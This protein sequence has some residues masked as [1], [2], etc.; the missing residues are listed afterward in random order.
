MR[1]CVEQCDGDYDCCEGN[2]YCYVIVCKYDVLFCGGVRWCLVWCDI[3]EKLLIFMD[4][5]GLFFGGW[6]FIFKKI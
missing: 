6:V 4:I 1:W 5:N 3:I 2:V